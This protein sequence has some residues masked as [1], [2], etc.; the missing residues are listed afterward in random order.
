RSDP[1]RAAS[2]QPRL[3]KRPWDQ[4]LNRPAEEHAEKGDVTQKK[5]P[6]VHRRGAR[7]KED[8]GVMIKLRQHSDR[9]LVRE[10]PHG[11]LGAVAERQMWV[12][13]GV[14]P[15]FEM[16]Y[17]VSPLIA[18]R[19]KPGTGGLVEHGIEE[20]HTLDHAPR[21]SGLS[22]SIVRL[23]DSRPKRLVVDVEHPS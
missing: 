9:Q 7:Y 11:L 12:L 1:N 5:Q 21:G 20:H 8:E 14:E 19:T 15:A 3:P 4:Q 17:E 10:V 2:A 23:A 6:E 22:E 16:T 13:P 18:C